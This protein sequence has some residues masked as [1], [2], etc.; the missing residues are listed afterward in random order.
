MS[1][2]K[3]QTWYKEL[4]EDCSGIWTEGVFNHKWQ[5]IETYHA[6]GKRIREEEKN[7]PVS[8]LVVKVSKDLDIS[9]RSVWHSVQF[10]DKFP[11]IN[12]L[13]QGKAI[14][15]SKVKLLVAGKDIEKCT[16]ENVKQ[17]KICS[18]CQRRI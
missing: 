12:K 10:V 8:E 16:H 7:L 5:L 1:N 3:T 11:D 18:G 2:L 9:E 6:L 13:P 15:W 14:S 17:I 4:L